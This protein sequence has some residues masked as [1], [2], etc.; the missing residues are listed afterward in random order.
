MRL[1]QDRRNTIL[2]SIIKDTFKKREDRIAKRENVLALRIRDVVL[3]KH[4]TAY[5][6]LPVGFQ[7][8]ASCVNANVGGRFI[9]LAFSVWSPCPSVTKQPVFI[10]GSPMEARISKWMNDRDDLNKERGDL[11]E[12]IS[13]ALYSVTTH[14]RLVEIW[15]AVEKYLP[16][17]SPNNLP[18][19]RVKELDQQIA[20]AKKT[21]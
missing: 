8:I 12:K 1:T 9:Q 19:I 17:D 21:T 13:A 16:A 20:A 14:K 5:L 11:R 7:R 6:S 4:K 18:A 3:A 15:P 2:S 10:V